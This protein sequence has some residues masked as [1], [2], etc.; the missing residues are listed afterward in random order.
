MELPCVCE[1]ML[2]SMPAFERNAVVGIH[3]SSPNCIN[4]ATPDAIPE[5]FDFIDY[6][7]ERRR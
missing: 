7:Y 3:C 6:F 1:R 5:Y 2:R 4:K